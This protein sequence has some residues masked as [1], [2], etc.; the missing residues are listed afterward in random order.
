MG[1]LRKQ[2][3]QLEN[4]AAVKVGEDSCMASVV[5]EEALRSGQILDEFLRAIH[6]D[7]SNG[8]DVGCE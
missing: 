8:L 4:M 1:K 5:T 6:D 2:E 7:F 3:D